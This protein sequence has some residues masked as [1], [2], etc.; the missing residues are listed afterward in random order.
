M[1]EQREETGGIARHGLDMVVSAN[2]LCAG[3][4]IPCTAT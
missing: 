3:G 2:G 4:L 1:G